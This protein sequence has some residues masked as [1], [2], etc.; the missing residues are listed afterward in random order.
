MN[1][2]RSSKMNEEI[3]RSFES[4]KVGDGIDSYRAIEDV[5]KIGTEMDELSRI[6]LSLGCISL[7]NN[8][9]ALAVGGVIIETR[10]KTLNEKREELM[11]SNSDN[12]EYLTVFT[13]VERWL[14]KNFLKRRQKLDFLEEKLGIKEEKK[15]AKKRRFSFKEIFN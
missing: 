2:E 6:G 7:G 12:D 14:E 3:R 8:E 5:L 13:G 10:M 15:E 11:K 4:L 9:A 1:K